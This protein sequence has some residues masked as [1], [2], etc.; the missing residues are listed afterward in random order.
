MG[1]LGTAIKW[2][3]GAVVVGGFVVVGAGVFLY[4][5]LK[6]LASFEGNGGETVRTIELVPGR[7][8]R[9]VSAPGELE[10]RSRVSISARVAAL[11]TELP[12]EEGDL[13]K[14]GDVVVR[15]DDKDLRAQMDRAEATFRSERARFEAARAEYINAVSNWERISDLFNSEDVSK[16][17]L[18]QAVQRMETA[19][20]NQNAAEHSI[21]V[22]QAGVDQARENLK[23]ATITSPIDGR[24]TTVNAEVG[25]LV[26]T[27]TMNNPG[28]VILEVADLSDM[29]DRA[30][31]DEIDIAEIEIGQPT[32]VSINAYPDEVFEGEVRL[33][34]LQSAFSTQDR[35]KIYE[36]E[37]LLHLDEGRTLLSGLTA[38]V[39]IE[40]E[41]LEGVL[42]APSQAVQEL[43]TDELP[44]EIR[45]DPNI[46][47]AKTFT[48][49]IYRVENGRA[50]ASPVRIGPS[51]LTT[52]AIEA[53]LAQ[54]DQII[55]GPWKMLQKL[56]HN[57]AVRPESSSTASA[58]ETA[59]TGAEPAVIASG[60][61]K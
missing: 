25:E 49:V 5:S 46:D 15:L 11:I 35:A 23:Y 45:N 57:M 16:A 36:T 8:V 22:A 52:T 13:V 9:T 61:A 33:V 54:G 44:D 24:V 10:P 47:Q 50:L 41:T 31:I 4:P 40:I 14:A 42:L 12:Y 2:T 43:R 48:R 60:A 3:M 6:K 39:D 27:G 34:S 32:R 29:I 38:N 37:I 19:E 17:E 1:T 55:V 59:D 18:D 56:E 7:L 30:E 58:P 28:T 53:G 21:A 26:V 20:A 51:D